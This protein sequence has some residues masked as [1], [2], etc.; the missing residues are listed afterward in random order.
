MA[1]KMV[2]QGINNHK[3]ALDQGVRDEDV[4]KDIWLHA[5]TPSTSQLIRHQHPL[6]MG[7]LMSSFVYEP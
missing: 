4:W 3:Q 2:S 7:N 1:W 5:E 6:A